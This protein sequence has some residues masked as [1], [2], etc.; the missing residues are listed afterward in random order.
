MNLPQSHRLLILGKRVWVQRK[1]NGK[2]FKIVVL[3]TSCY[4]RKTW[5]ST[6]MLL[7]EMKIHEH[8][9]RSIKAIMAFINVGVARPT[10]L[11]KKL[12]IFLFLHCCI[13]FDTIFVYNIYLHI[14][15]SLNRQTSNCEAKSLR[16]SSCIEVKKNSCFV[17]YQ[18]ASCPFFSVGYL[19]APRIQIKS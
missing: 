7:A 9:W 19:P 8:W 2:C 15:G 1:R 18:L 5:R 16:V 12:L 11:I 6:C 14:S 10:P 4:G 13:H 17:K 3:V